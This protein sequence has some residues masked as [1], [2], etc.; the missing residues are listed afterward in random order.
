MN[1]H[2]TTF[3]STL[4]LDVD[5]T[6]YLI[7]FIIISLFEIHEKLLKFISLY[8]QV[9]VMYRILYREHIPS[10]LLKECPSEIR[11]IRKIAN[12]IFTVHFIVKI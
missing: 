11:I 5:K 10:V 12:I 1:L 4:I 6:K 8:Y 3:Q 2:A 7:K 9:F